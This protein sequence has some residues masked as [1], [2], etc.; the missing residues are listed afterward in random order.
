MTTF[1]SKEVA[2]GLEAARKKALTKKTKLCI[3]QDGETIR[4]LKLWDDGFAVNLARA[5]ELR[6]LVDLYDGMRHLYQ[7]LIITAQEV[8]GEMHYEFKRNSAAQEKPPLD[9]APRKQTP[10][11]YLTHG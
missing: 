9:F 11:G 2:A 1:V 8:D 6:G 4:V 7:C 10:V 3:H 5:P